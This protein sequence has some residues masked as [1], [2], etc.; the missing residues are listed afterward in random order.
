MGGQVQQRDFLSEDVR[1]GFIE[2]KSHKW[3]CERWAGVSKQ[4]RKHISHR[5]LIKRKDENVEPVAC[6]GSRGGQKER[7]G[8]YPV[9]DF[10]Y[11]FV[12][13]RVVPE[14]R[15]LTQPNL[16]FQKKIRMADWWVNWS[17]KK[18][19]RHFL[20]FLFL[21][22]LIM[23]ASLRVWRRK[24]EMKRTDYKMCELES[25]GGGGRKWGV[26]TFKHF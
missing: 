2:E 10:Q 1:E 25:L 22:S 7:L 19:V 23:Q 9:K 13:S 15:G 26:K 16:D 8:L 4:R 11:L 24:V 20:L 12:H 6:V 3:S 21:K 5:D 14:C 17:M 18:Q